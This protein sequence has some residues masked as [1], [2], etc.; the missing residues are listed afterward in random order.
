MKKI[1]VLSTVAILA[2]ILCSCGSDDNADGNIY[3]T[4]VDSVI[5]FIENES[6]DTDINPDD[7]IYKSYDKDGITYNLVFSKTQ[8]S[9]KDVFYLT[10]TMEIEDKFITDKISEDADLSEEL[11]AENPYVATT[12][13]NH[14]GDVWFY[15]VKVMDD[16][17]KVTREGED[18]NSP[19]KNIYV[20]T[21]ETEPVLE[22]VQVKKED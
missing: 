6:G 21:G 5:G 12:M 8:N 15:I 10:R 7:Y 3:D 20:E 22:I 18:A 2:L 13:Q 14:E 17:Y 1:L 16:S 19:H 9:D 4:Y 11:T